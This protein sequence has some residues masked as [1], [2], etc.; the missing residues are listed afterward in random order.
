MCKICFLF[1]RLFSLFPFNFLLKIAKI[2]RIFSLFIYFFFRLFLYN[3]QYSLVY[4]I[5]ISVCGLRTKKRRRK[6]QAKLI[7]VEYITNVKIYLC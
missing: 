3:V 4:H 1:I 6:Y 7:F 2:R 5:I